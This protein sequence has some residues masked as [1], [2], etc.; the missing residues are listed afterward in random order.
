MKIKVCV[1][2]ANGGVKRASVMLY[3]TKNLGLKLDLYS[4]YH[5][6]IAILEQLLQEQEIEND[7]RETNE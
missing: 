7:V 4:Y 6:D 5:E 2:N 1:E 3:S